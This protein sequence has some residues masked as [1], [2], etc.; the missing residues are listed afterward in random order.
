MSNFPNQQLTNL[1]WDALS[2]ALTGERLLFTRMIA[3]DGE[4]PPGADP[5]DL[6]EMTELVNYV[7]DITIVGLIPHGSGRATVAG[8]LNSRDIA[9]GFFLR[10]I[11]L[12]VEVG[13]PPRPA[14]L[15]SICNA[16]DQASYV[17]GR[18]EASKVVTGIELHIIIGKAI[19]IDVIIQA[20]AVRGENIGD[21]P[22]G[23]G[24]YA[25]QSGLI[26]Q[27]K[28]LQN[29]D[30][31]MEIVENVR[32][33]TFKSSGAHAPL[34]GEPGGPDDPGPQPPN[35]LELGLIPV[36]TILSYAGRV[37][38]IG[39]FLCAGQLVSRT[40]FARLFAVI[41]IDYGPGDGIGTFN[42]PNLETRIPLGAGAGYALADIGG[43]PNVIL[44]EAQ[45]AAHQHRGRTI[46][47]DHAIGGNSGTV[48]VSH[49]HG[50][51]F[52]QHVYTDIF[53]EWP[54]GIQYGFVPSGPF[55]ERNRVSQD[56]LVTG[57]GII[58]DPAGVGSQI[59]VNVQGDIADLSDATGGN[60]G[61][62]NMPPYIA[63]NYII[64]Y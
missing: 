18:D 63:I 50:G 31:S 2:D 48:A 5:D 32:N 6:T 39:H 36:G 25:A 38:P 22:E 7:M 54:A 45:L 1:G 19:N 35:G 30:D 9:N 61:H 58:T 41:G 23:A 59:F 44:T 43:V 16:A 4:L 53:D 52:H 12:M 14:V 62:T 47:H 57:A 34:P 8:V 24:V 64:K 13:D 33:I 29:E 3:G 27:F 56:R 55:A 49:V 40:D 42:L 17:P 21:P 20:G 51:G 37:A 60:Q 46:P 15:Y 28:R 26:L 11:G 10:E